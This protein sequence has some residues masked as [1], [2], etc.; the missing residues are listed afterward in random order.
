MI[1][2]LY[3]SPGLVDFG[4]LVAELRSVDPTVI[5]AN[6]VDGSVAIYTPNQ[7]DEAALAVVVSA[8]A[9]PPQYQPLDSAGALAT[10]LVVTGVLTLTDA[11]NAIGQEPAHLIAEAEAWSLGT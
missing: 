3:S 5:D 10:L 2:T 4:L 9:G 7:P 1:R 8:H 6:D 11:S